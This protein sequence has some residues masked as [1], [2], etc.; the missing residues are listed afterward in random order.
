MRGWDL[1]RVPCIA[2]SVAGSASGSRSD[3]QYRK[4]EVGVVNLLRGGV[5]LVG[6]R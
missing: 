3:S 1:L 6:P 2:L 4:V 5:N